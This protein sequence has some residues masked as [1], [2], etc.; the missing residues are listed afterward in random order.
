[1][2]RIPAVIGY[3]VLFALGIGAAWLVS[4]LIGL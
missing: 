2:S 1:M 4:K 3:P